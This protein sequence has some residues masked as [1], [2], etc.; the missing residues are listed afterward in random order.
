MCKDGP[1]RYLKWVCVMLGLFAIPSEPVLG[2]A[3]SLSKVGLCKEEPA[4]YP[5]GAGG[6]SEVGKNI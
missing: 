4:C 3:C 2:W 5:K 1:G 6:G